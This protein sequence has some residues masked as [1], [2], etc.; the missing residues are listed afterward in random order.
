MLLF[1]YLFPYDFF[2][3]F[4]FNKFVDIYKNEITTSEIWIHAYLSPFPIIIFWSFL[5]K[6]FGMIFW[7]LHK[8]PSKYLPENYN[9]YIK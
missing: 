4:K 5:E 8:Y 6:I 9:L 3:H 7:K 2:S 1:F